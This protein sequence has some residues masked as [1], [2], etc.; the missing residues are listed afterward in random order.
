M[1]KPM[2]GEGGDRTR[3]N[4]VLKPMTVTPKLE[5]AVRPAALSDTVQ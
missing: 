4:V 3:T 2:P 1:W 5:T